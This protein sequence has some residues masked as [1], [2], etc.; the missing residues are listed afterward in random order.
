[1]EFV[2]SAATRFKLKQL[3]R[4]PL[5]LSCA[6]HCQWNFVDSAA[7][8][9]ELK[10]LARTSWPSVAPPSANGILLNSAATP[11]WSEPTK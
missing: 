8:R 2:D 1:M 10:E 9:F 5:A 3:A 7:T 11:L 6:A 4:I